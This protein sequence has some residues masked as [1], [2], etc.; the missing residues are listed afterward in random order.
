VN[1][2]NTYVY[3]ILTCLGVPWECKGFFNYHGVSLVSSYKKLK[4]IHGHV[5]FFIAWVVLLS[6]FIKLINLVVSYLINF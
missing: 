1:F 4:S 6:N 5:L 3:K 2:T